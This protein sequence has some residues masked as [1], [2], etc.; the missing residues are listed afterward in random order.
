M[1]VQML[2]WKFGHW[3]NMPRSAG[4]YAVFVDRELLYIGTAS[5]FRDRFRHHQIGWN[6]LA[7]RDYK[8]NASTAVIA[9]KVYD[10]K[11]DAVLLE[12]SLIRKL[13]PPHNICLKREQRKPNG[14]GR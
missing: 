14:G 12:A 3:Q 5:D 1:P 10:T 2:G 8:G 11:E 6:R 13:Q 4:I 9:Y 7:Y